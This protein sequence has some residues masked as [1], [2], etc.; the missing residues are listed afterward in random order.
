M[1]LAQQQSSVEIQ[2][3]T[4]HVDHRPERSPRL[5]NL[6]QKLSIDCTSEAIRVR[7]P[8]LVVLAAPG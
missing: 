4:P 6:L 7:E 2:P 1:R 8:Q 3:L 5:D